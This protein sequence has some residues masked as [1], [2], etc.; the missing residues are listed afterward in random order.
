MLNSDK[1]EKKNQEYWRS[2]VDKIRKDSLNGSHYLA[3]EALVVIEEFIQKKLYNNRTE[4]F[5]SYSKLVNALV[6]AKPLMALIYARSHRILDFIEN[7]PKEERNIKAVQKMV[8]NE[9]QNI[10]KESATRE[11]RSAIGPGDNRLTTMADVIKATNALS[12]A[13]MIRPMTQMIPIRSTTIG[14]HVEKNVSIASRFL[15]P[16]RGATFFPVQAYI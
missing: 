6:R 10:R 8:L 15:S 4:L 13:T 9:I 14:Y 1:L 12:R 7:I 3:D 16:E 5:Q 2:E 11:T